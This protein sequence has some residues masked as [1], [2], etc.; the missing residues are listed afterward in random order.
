MYMAWQR[1]KAMAA[2]LG[3]KRAPSFR[4]RCGR[5]DEHAALA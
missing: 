3:N 5:L 4:R 1:G 2:A